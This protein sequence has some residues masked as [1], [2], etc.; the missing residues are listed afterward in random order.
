MDDEDAARS[1]PT[2]SL[3]IELVRRLLME[4]ARGAFSMIEWV[5]FFVV[6]CM[7]IVLLIG[8]LAAFVMLSLYIGSLYRQAK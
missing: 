6:L 2:R 3:V 7:G 1:V 5:A 4:C 8:A